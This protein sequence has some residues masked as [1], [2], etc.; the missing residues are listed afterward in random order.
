[1]EKEGLTLGTMCLREVKRLIGS[2]VLDEGREMRWKMGKE[3]KFP[4]F[5]HIT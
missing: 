3:G 4:L 2:E 5:C 1:M